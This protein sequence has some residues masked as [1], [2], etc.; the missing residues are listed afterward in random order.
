M[1][2]WSEGEILVCEDG[3]L[4]GISPEEHERR[5]AAQTPA[6]RALMEII[7]GNFAAAATFMR[8]EVEMLDDDQC[9]TS[10]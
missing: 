1:K 8:H 9:G 4:V 6:Q 5:L 2:I 3:K 10:W 7:A